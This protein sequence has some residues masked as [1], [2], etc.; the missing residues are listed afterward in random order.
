[1]CRQR[2]SCMKAE[3]RRLELHRGL[4]GD[5]LKENARIS[6][7]NALVIINKGT[8]QWEK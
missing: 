1:M 3:V 4:E 8:Y 7:E 2:G 5:F 6:L